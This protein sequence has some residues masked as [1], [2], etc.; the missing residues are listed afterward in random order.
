MLVFRM[1]ELNSRKYRPQVSVAVYAGN[2]LIHVAVTSVE[3]VS[4]GMKSHLIHQNYPTLSAT[5]LVRQTP[6]NLVGVII[7]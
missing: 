4:A 6:T 2:F 1:L 5:F 3:N 7:Q